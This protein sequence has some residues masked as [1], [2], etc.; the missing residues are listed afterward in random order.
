MPIPRL[1][2]WPDELN[3]W[4]ETTMSD[5]QA[6]PEEESTIDAIGIDPDMVSEESRPDAAE[7]DD[8]EDDDADAV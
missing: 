7:S 6:V 1:R 8:T 5:P 2:R 4:M 3:E